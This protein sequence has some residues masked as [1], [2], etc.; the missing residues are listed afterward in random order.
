MSDNG[1]SKRNPEAHKRIKARGYQRRKLKYLDYNR[2][3]KYGVG[4]A[5]VLALIEQQGGV[6]PITGN[7]LSVNSCVDHDH[8]TGKVRGILS[9]KANAFLGH[10]EKNPE[11]F[12]RALAYLKEHGF[13][14]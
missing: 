3:K 4:N 8:A 13:G 1:W 7:K 10:I 2:K 6:C 9:I 11:F 12:K 14:M 5:E